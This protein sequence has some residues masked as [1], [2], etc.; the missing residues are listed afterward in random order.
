MVL[1]KSG[2][3]RGEETS[4]TLVSWF[5]WC[6]WWLDTGASSWT[7]AAGHAPAVTSERA[8]ATFSEYGTVGGLLPTGDGGVGG[9]VGGNGEGSEQGKSRPGPSGGSACTSGCSCAGVVA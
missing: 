2:A 7:K 6:D 4:S 9:G 1:L 3:C 8:V 5:A